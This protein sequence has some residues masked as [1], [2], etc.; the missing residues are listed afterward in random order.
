[1][2]TL[3][4]YD[5]PAS[6][7]CL[8]V[9]IL[10][11]HL[12]VDYE[13]VHTDIFGGETLTESYAEKNPAQQTP[14]LEVDGVYLP[15]SNA[16]LWYLAECTQYLPAH[17]LARANVV[18]WLHFEQGWVSA[19]SSL[20]FRLQTGRLDPD[21]PTVATRRENGRQ[22]LAALDRHLDENLFLVD[23]EYSIADIANYAYVH[24]A[25]EIA[26]PLEEFPAVARW[27]ESVESQSG[28]INDLLPLPESSRLRRGLSLYG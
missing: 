2:P 11:A 20:R 9:R 27:I 19:I 17:A 15:E 28:F 7:N 16:I 3:R 18:R 25:H 6:G 14:L 24:V 1:M 23:D 10:L 21:D 4:L 12:G 22:A 5:Y 8:K 26:I 13:R